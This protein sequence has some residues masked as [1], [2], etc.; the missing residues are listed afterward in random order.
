MHWCKKLRHIIVL[1]GISIKPDLNNYIMADLN[2][3]VTQLPFMIFYLIL[4]RFSLR[5]TK[6]MSENTKYIIILLFKSLLYFYFWTVD[7]N[8][9]VN[10]NPIKIN[11]TKN[12]LSLIHP[13]NRFDKCNHDSKIFTIK[14]FYFLPQFMYKCRDHFSPW[15][16][17]NHVQASK[18][19]IM[20]KF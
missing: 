9:W 10:S 15:I 17:I 13:C 20:N 16:L 6:I 19:Q 2:A 18:Q 12:N 8:D 14:S 7:S 1:W 4:T 3:Q 5:A 11:S